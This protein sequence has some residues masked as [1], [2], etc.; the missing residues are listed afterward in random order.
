VRH[1][2]ALS[3]VGTERLQES[4]YFRAKLVQENLIAAAGIPYTIV[5][6]TQFFEFMAA[7]RRRAPTGKWFVP[8]ALMQ[9]MLATTSRQRWGLHARAAVESQSSKSPG[10]KRWAST[11]PSEGS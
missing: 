3:V 9:P 6:A 11:K 10:P 2:I 7:S 4:G 5:R 8:S 1:H